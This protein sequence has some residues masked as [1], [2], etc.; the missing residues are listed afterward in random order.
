MIRNIL[1]PTDFSAGAAA[2]L[3]S[4]RE[5]AGALGASLHL[6]HVV[7]DPFFAGSVSEVYAPPPR[8]PEEAEGIARQRLEACLSGDDKVKLHAVLAATSGVPA[9]EILHR[10]EQDPPIHLVVM[11]THGRGGVSRMVM[12][13]VADKIVRHAPCP[14]M[15]VKDGWH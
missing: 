9:N 14:V 6:L 7:E 15:T 2:A 4:A 10:L 8:P 13:S 5:L 1:V 11:A 3:A 12:G